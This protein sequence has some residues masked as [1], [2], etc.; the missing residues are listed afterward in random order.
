[1]AAIFMSNLPEG[2]S[3]AAG[4]KSSGRTAR[5]V[6]GVWVTIAV[7]TGVAGLL[8]VLLLEAA[9]P[10]TIAAITELAAGAILAM[11]ADTMIPEA[12][13]KTHLYAG[14]AATVG[15]MASFVLSHA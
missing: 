11:V 2:L 4:M 12:F 6:F 14:L 9:E 13:E 10:K 5:Y 8:G 7:A 1:F 15:F 3:S